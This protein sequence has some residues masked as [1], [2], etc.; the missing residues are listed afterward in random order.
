M[1]KKETKTIVSAKFDNWTVF[2]TESTEP[3][4]G[5]IEF[6]AKKNNTIYWLSACQGNIDE[7]DED[8]LFAAFDDIKETLEFQEKAIDL[9][10]EVQMDALMG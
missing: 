6:Y 4:E 7:V 5:F 9:V 8:L 2:A 10:A 3:K 1:T